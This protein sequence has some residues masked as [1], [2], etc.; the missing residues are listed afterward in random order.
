MKKR[1]PNQFIN[2]QNNVLLF[3]KPLILMMKRLLLMIIFVLYGG[4]ITAQETRMSTEVP[5]VLEVKDFL[6]YLRSSEHASRTTFSNAQNVEDLMYKSQPSVYFY[7]GIVKSYGEKPKCL[8]TD[9]QSL[10]NLESAGILKNNIEMVTIKIDRAGDLNAT[11]DMSV[12][13]SFKNMKYIY[14]VS[15]TNTTSQV[16]SRMIRNSDEKYGVFYRI[17]KGDNN[18]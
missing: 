5:P 7:S 16:V 13:S 11:I 14:I 4:I 8:F 12:F 18:R 6:A 10:N 17:D 3:R 15:S 2:Q 1:V 9:F